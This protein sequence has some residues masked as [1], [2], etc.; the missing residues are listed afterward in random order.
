MFQIDIIYGMPY[1]HALIVVNRVLFIVRLVII[2]LGIIA[3]HLYRELVTHETPF[4]TLIVV[5]SEISIYSSIFPDTGNTGS[6][7]SSGSSRVFT[8]GVLVRAY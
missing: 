2:Q 3:K 5:S 4:K 6:S 1:P 8:I 7:T